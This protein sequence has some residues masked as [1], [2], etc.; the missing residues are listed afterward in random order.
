[1]ASQYPSDILQDLFNKY[2]LS[3][4]AAHTSSEHEV[5]PNRLCDLCLDAVKVYT[6]PEFW[7][8]DGGADGG[9]DEEEIREGGRMHPPL[10]AFYD[11]FD[12]LRHSAHKGCHLCS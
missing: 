8:G 4:T 11:S 9:W 10:M 7:D 5:I 6:G 1:M 2:S 12:I 3:S